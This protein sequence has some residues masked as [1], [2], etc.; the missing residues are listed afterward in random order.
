MS[1]EDIFR[2][3]AD[4]THIKGDTLAL[5]ANMGGTVTGQFRKHSDEA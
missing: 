3:P 5:S 2:R 1:Q 4:N